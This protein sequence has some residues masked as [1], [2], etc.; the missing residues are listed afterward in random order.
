LHNRTGALWSHFND[1][2]QALTWLAGIHPLRQKLNEEHLKNICGLLS[3]STSGQSNIYGKLN[4]PTEVFPIYLRKQRNVTQDIM[5]FSDCCSDRLLYII[6]KHLDVS[7][8]SFE[9][10]PQNLANVNLMFILS[11]LIVANRQV[12]EILEIVDEEFG[13]YLQLS[14]E[15]DRINPDPTRHEEI[16]TA[17][18]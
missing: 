13:P 4:N 1:V 11:D 18:P 10:Y 3:T 2:K 6:N 8:R 12:E 15:A 16:Y 7:E 5:R 14:V 17:R 9:R